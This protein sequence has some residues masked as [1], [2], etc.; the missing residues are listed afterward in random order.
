VFVWVWLLGVAGLYDAGALVH[1]LLIP[2]AS[3]LIMAAR[4][5]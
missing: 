3:L 2:A 4:T 1:V 5:A